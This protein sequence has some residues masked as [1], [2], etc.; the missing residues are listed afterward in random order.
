[1]PGDDAAMARL[2]IRLA[3]VSPTHHRLTLGREDG[4]SESR[5]LETRSCL[6]HDLLHF[7]LETEAGLRQSFYGL[8]AAGARYEQLTMAGTVSPE[9]VATERIVGGLTGALRHRAPAEDFVAAMQSAFEAHGE[10]LPGWCTSE[11]VARVG[12]RMR[13]LEGEWRALPFGQPMELRFES[14]E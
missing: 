2:V 11:L 12:E 6:Y 10:L 4:S 14:G 3:R 5:E 7:A 13:R 9:I 8:L 1:M